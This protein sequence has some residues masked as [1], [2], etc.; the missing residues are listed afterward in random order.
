MVVECFPAKAVFLF[1]SEDSARRAAL[2]NCGHAHCTHSHTVRILEAA[3]A[4][5]DVPDMF[6]D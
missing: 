4:P 3:R 2:D 6:W 1:Q 5:R